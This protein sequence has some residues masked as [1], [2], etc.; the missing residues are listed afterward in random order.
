LIAVGGAAVGI[1][2][3][4]GGSIRFPA[5]FNGVIGFKSG[6]HRVSQAGHFPFTE[7]PLQARMLGIGALAKSVDDARLIN[8]ILSDYP[9]EEKSLSD[10]IVSIP[11]VQRQYPISGDTAEQLRRVKEIVS[12]ENRVTEDFP[13][14]FEKMARLW[15][16]IMSID[17]GES[18]ARIALGN[19][20]PL[21]EY[22]KEIFTQ[23]SDIHRYLTWAV[24]GANMFRPRGKQLAELQETLTQLD[25]ESAE[26]FRG[27]ILVLPVY[28]SPAL[29]HGQVYKQIFSVRKS[30]LR[31]MPFVSVAN[32]AG[33][34]SLVIPAGASSSGLPISVQLISAVGNEQALFQ[35]G[36]ILEMR[37]RG[38]QRCISY[39]NRM[40]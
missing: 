20:S 13:P 9:G 12:G 40:E 33:L 37:L 30:F 34:P 17:G 10:F 38:Y 15:Q 22:I 6:S 23:N 7:N 31:Y 19:R 24:I 39:D 5:H 18:I 4:I 29:P 36:K 21:I 2:S 16:L 26:Y 8:E 32:V 27:R 35:L 3:D 25:Q 11:P 28:H 14:M 1:G